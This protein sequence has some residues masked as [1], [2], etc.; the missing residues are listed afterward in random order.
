MEID[1]NFIPVPNREGNIARTEKPLTK[2]I[3]DINF[4]ACVPVA[5][6][7]ADATSSVHSNNHL[8]SVCVS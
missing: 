4:K 7:P 2:Q 1:P 8:D 5:E 3:H 6:T